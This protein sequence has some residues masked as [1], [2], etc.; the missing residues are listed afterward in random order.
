MVIILEDMALSFNNG[1]SS[2]LYQA[3]DQTWPSNMPR[4]TEFEF[5][6]WHIVINHF[7][8]TYNTIYTWTNF[9]FTISNFFGMIQS[10]LRPDISVGLKG[11][12]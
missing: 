7:Q 12:I 11:F 9:F 8:V 5:L 4:K 2:M 1:F 3:L 6:F 10:V